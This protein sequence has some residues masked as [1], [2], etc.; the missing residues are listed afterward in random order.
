MIKKVIK[1]KIPQLD[2]LRGLAAIL[3]MFYHYD[4]NYLPS[5]LS[6]F[7]LIR[8]GW[9]FVDFFFVLSGFV[10]AYNYSFQFNKIT[11]F[12]FIKLRFIRIYPLLFFS[13][14]VFAFFIIIMFNFNAC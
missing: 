1:Q 12:K 5:F 6:D 4:I 8:Q 3:V 14:I 10:I 7:F 13:V 11:L 9:I 2:A